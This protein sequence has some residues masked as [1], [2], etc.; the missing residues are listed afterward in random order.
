MVSI[1]SC[2][3]FFGFAGGVVAA[4]AGVADAGVVDAYSADAGTG[5]VGTFFGCRLLG[6]WLLCFGGLFLGR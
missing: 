6:R 1:G 3:F 2:F 5:D 4:D